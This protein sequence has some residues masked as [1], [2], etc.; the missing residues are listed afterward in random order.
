MEQKLISEPTIKPNSFREESLNNFIP[1]ILYQ[2]EEKIKKASQF[3]TIN[4]NSKEIFISSKKKD[5]E[6][7][8]HTKPKLLKGNLP[9]VFNVIEKRHSSCDKKKYSD[10]KFNNSNYNLN[11]ERKDISPVMKTKE[12][13]SNTEKKGFH[14]YNPKINNF[15]R[16]KALSPPPIIFNQIRDQSKDSENILISEVNN[17]DIIEENDSKG[18]TNFSDFENRT[19][20]RNKTITTNFSSYGFGILNDNYI[21]NDSLSKF[22]NGMNKNH[23]VSFYQKQFFPFGNESKNNNNKKYDNIYIEKK[24]NIINANNKTNKDI[25]NKINININEKGLVKRSP[26]ETHEKNNYTIESMKEEIFNYNY[27]KNKRISTHQNEQKDNCKYKN[28]S[29]DNKK[30]RKS[31]DNNNFINKINLNEGISYKLLNGYKYHFNLLNVDIY[32]LK[33]I[34]NFYVNKLKEQIKLWKNKYNKESNESIFLKILDIKI[35]IPEN[36]STI[37]ME[38][39]IGSESLT[40]IINSIGFKDENILIKIVSKLYKNIL[41]FKDD[42]YF[43]N[44]PF[45]LCDIFLDVYEQIKIIPPLIRKISYFNDKYTKNDKCICKYYLDKIKDIFEI[46][47]NYISNFF[48][49]FTLIQLISQNFIF[50]M[51]S[52]DI[53]IHNKNNKDL[54]KCCLIHTL[55]T[56]E[57]LFCDKKEDLLLSNFL[58]LYPKTLI[59]LLHECTDFKGKN[60]NQTFERL[61]QSKVKYD[62]KIQMKELLKLVELPNNNYCKL[63]DFL[64]NFEILYKNFNINFYYFNNCLKKKKII[65][66]LSRTFNIKKEELV[67]FFLKIIYNAEK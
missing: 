42:K 52:F 63:S 59:Q 34:N 2:Q 5:L 43:S 61:I 9:K 19:L 31:I 7:L 35:N 37:I 50:K 64:R 18:K 12:Y 11:L 32:L 48:L 62:S 33:E 40:N 36:H 15:I 67:N 6:T 25:I 14:N 44:I 66:C 56:I 27:N 57:I 38:Y 39:P 29:F 17:K 45:C 49:G 3:K 58:E 30:I 28:F 55:I 26:S 60:I 16:E 8:I 13:A 20:I 65:S 1:S 51:K 46:N 41:F 21:Y 53:L 4:N 47:N 10:N 24:S 22:N 54:K 23:I